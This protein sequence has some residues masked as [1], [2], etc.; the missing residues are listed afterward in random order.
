MQQE[1]NRLKIK[2]STEKE[3]VSRSQRE[4]TASDLEFENSKQSLTRFRSKIQDLQNEI[5]KLEHDPSTQ[6]TE[7]Q[8]A[9]VDKINHLQDGF[10]KYKET[11]VTDLS[12]IQH[13]LEQSKADNTRL[14]Q[15][16]D[17]KLSEVQEQLEQS[18]ADNPRLQQE[19]ETK[20][21]GVQ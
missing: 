14:L 11:S 21:S 18:R 5:H 19:N 6:A 7:D 15:E 13:Q 2:L 10:A 3:D 16:N 1:S 9:S 4:K 8:Q 12:K 20:L 17:T